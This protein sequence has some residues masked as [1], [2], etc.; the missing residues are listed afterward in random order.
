V[1]AEKARHSVRTLCRVLGVSAS[2]FYAWQHRPASPRAAA[3]HRLRFQLRVAHAESR[4]AYGSPRLQRVL[5][6]QG[7]RV[8][9]HRVM[10]LMRAEHLRGRPHRRFRLTT[11]A[12]PAA[13]VAPNHLAQR[14]T[15]ARANQVWMGDITALP[16]QEGWIYLAVLIDVFSRRVVGWALEPT[17]ETRLVLRAWD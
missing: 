11:V 16:T 6:T 17:L 5:R 1:Q 8:G 13:V 10:R 7:V 3:D 12:D 4:G 15:A 9:R 14:F 2:G